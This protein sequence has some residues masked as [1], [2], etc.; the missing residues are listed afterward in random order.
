MASEKLFTVGVDLGLLGGVFVA[1]AA[2]SY[3]CSRKMPTQPCNTASS[4]KGGSGSKDV[5]VR[6]LAAFILPFHKGN[7]RIGLAVLEFT[8]TYGHEGRKSVFSFGR[9]TGR[10]HAMLEL[11][12]VPYAL[13]PPQL[14]QS[15]VFPSGGAGDTKACS[16]AYAQGR[17]PM[18][19][20]P[21]NDGICDAACLA[22]Y[23]LDHLQG[24]HGGD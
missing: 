19:K 23:G 9:G 16:I 21:R 14:W 7:C 8:T 10:V 13:V 22:A 6:E 12:D 20:L 4:P 3:V 24:G 15:A 2:G 1:T 11:L 5:D 18:A 17:W